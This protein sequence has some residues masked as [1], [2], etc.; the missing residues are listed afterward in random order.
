[1]ASKEE[2]NEKFFTKEGIKFIETKIK[3][4][5]KLSNDNQ[6]PVSVKILGFGDLKVENQEEIIGRII[7]LCELVGF[8]INIKKMEI[9]EDKEYHIT[10]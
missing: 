5:I 9:N 7:E 2:L 4:M 10:Y 3:T 8:Q 1:M 6:F